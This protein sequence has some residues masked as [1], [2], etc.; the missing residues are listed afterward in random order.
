MKVIGGVR[1][2]FA[3][4]CVCMCSKCVYRL[5]TVI[6]NHWS[7]R[8]SS[9]TASRKVIPINRTH[10]GMDSFFVLSGLLISRG[11]QGMKSRSCLRRYGTF[12]VWRIFRI[13][14]MVVAAVAA[15]LLIFC[16]ILSKAFFCGFKNVLSFNF[17]WGWF[18]NLTD[19]NFPPG[20]KPTTYCKAFSSHPI[21]SLQFLLFIGMTSG[22]HYPEDWSLSPSLPLVRSST[23]GVDTPTAGAKSLCG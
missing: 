2:T 17:V 11:Y 19:R 12:L 1:V 10:W 7:N 23:L 18:S 16:C 4:I 15:G 5:I 3:I 20:L 22:R 21:Q 9:S 6:D 8:S 14:P 13:W